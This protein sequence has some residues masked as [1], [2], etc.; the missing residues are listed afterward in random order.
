MKIIISD[1]NYDDDDDNY[2]GLWLQG[3]HFVRSLLL[4]HD[5]TDNVQAVSL[6]EIL[7]PRYR[8]AAINSS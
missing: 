8:G 1:D 5:R 6:M 3:A 2:D 4:T 7:V